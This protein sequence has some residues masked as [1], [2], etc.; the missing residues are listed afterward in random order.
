QSKL[1]R[2][3][4]EQEFERVGGT[5]TL[6][7]DTRII[8]TTNRNLEREVAEGSFRRDLFYRL[9]VVRIRI[10]PLRERLDDIPALAAYFLCKFQGDARVPVRG[11]AS[12]TLQLLLAHDWPGNVREFRNV[13][14]SACIR[15]TTE[16]IAPDD[17]PPLRSTETHESG[18]GGT[19]L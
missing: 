13:I 18:A 10:P 5:R 11:L 15:A 6:R 17:L 14:H 12:A 8:A 16:I 3:L 9:N 7:I 4:E 1:L 19:T 2:V